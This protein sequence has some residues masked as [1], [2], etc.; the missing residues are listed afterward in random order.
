MFFCRFNGF[1]KLYWIIIKILW[2][3]YEMCMQSREEIMFFCRFNGFLN[4]SQPNSTNFQENGQIT[5]CQKT[6]CPI[7]VCQIT[8]CQKAVCQKTFC[9][10][11]DTPRTLIRSCVNLLWK[12]ALSKLYKTCRGNLPNGHLMKKCAKFEPEIPEN[13][14][15]M[16]KK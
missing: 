4:N 9:L 10:F 14:W 1:L 6:Y 11:T 15:E 5:Y 13:F 16:T 2:K 3:L 12:V 8:F 7:A